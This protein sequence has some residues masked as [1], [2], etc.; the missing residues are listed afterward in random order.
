M[1]IKNFRQLHLISG[2][3]SAMSLQY[4]VSFRELGSGI[5]E[6][7][8][9]TQK[10]YIDVMEEVVCSARIAFIEKGPKWEASMLL[11]PGSWLHKMFSKYGKRLFSANYRGF[12]GYY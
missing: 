6:H 9:V 7:F 3:Y 1:S 10:S 8:F 4:I 5:I 2:R 12:L 11:V